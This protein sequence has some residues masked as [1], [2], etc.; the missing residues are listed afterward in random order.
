MKGILTLVAAQAYAK[1][2]WDGRSI[3]VEKIPERFTDAQRHYYKLG[4]QKGVSDFCLFDE[5]QEGPE[6]WGVVSV[7]ND[8]DSSL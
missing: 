8:T 7:D 1:G 2:Y 6:A 3:G 5:G 4:Y